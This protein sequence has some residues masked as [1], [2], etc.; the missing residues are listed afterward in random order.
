MLI[1]NEPKPTPQFSQRLSLVEPSIQLVDGDELEAIMVMDID[2]EQESLNE[3]LSIFEKR[4]ARKIP[5]FNTHPS[6]SF[7][8]ISK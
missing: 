1:K 5:I 2:I 8:R 6:I 7:R 4:A 3:R